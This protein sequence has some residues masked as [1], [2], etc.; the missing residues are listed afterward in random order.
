M[1]WRYKLL[2]FG[3]A[4][5]FCTLLVAA[6]GVY[7]LHFV[8]T[9]AQNT[10]R[11][12]QERLGA[13]VDTRLAVVEIDR[14]LSRLVSAQTSDDQRSDALASIRAASALDETLAG[15]QQTLP[16]S[17][18]VEDLLKRNAVIKDG[19]M[20]VIRAARKGDVETARAQLTVI[21]PQMREVEELSRTIFT[22]EQAGITER[23]EAMQRAGRQA[24]IGMGLVAAVT[25]LLAF[26]LSGWVARVLTR[27]LAGLR[28]AMSDLAEGNLSRTLAQGGR[29][30]VGATLA[31]LAAAT[32]RLRDIVRQ[33]KGGSDQVI[34]K[35]VQLGG[36]G[37]R[38]T[39]VANTLAMVVNELRVSTEDVVRNA[40]L[41]STRLHDAVTVARGATA[42]VEATSGN[43]AEMAGQVQAFEQRVQNLVG[44]NQR[45]CAAVA[46][47]GRIIEEIQEISAQ[48]NL[49]ALNAAIE[50][51]RAGE[52]GRGFAVVADE[53]R[54]LATRA[55]S[56][57]DQITVITERITSVV[58][59]SSALLDEEAVVARQSASRLRG[60]Q[61][62]S[63]AALTG[64]L[65]AQKAMEETVDSFTNQEI[66][67]DEMAGRFCELVEM[68]AESRRQAELL[69]Q[70]AQ[71]L[72]GSATQLHDSVEVFQLSPETAG[73]AA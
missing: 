5:G 61:T 30:E 22:A 2:G 11:V 58:G 62:E 35:S 24:M 6:V 36:V 44:I 26:L 49:L 41:S 51:A 3:G 42:T 46:S 73:A 16:G 33:I 14:A 13:A 60:V 55:R 67:L 28:S 29:D 40:R 56:A 38:A 57:T 23:M 54:T 8:T 25:L 32:A 20:G 69:D 70:V 27:P 10:Q 4:L 21:G 1:G 9:M 48:T 18:Q 71:A 12:S 53:V 66:R 34:R 19:R 43:V 68:S 52:Q 47:I 65:A 31:S 15:L 59:E 7:A 17:A 45:T 39:D 64:A 72:S 37:A 50:A 63:A